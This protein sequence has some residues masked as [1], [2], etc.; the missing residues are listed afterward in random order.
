MIFSVVLVAT[1]DGHPGSVFTPRLI[2]K[3]ANRTTGKNTLVGSTIYKVDVTGF[4]VKS[5]FVT[6]EGMV[7]PLLEKQV[8]VPFIR[9]GRVV[10]SRHTY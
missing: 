2:Q 5:A 8:T 6:R 3:H 7:F 10:K 1:Q 4:Q 9:R